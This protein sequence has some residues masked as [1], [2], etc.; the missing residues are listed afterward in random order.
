MNFS[1]IIPIYN[2]EK[3]LNILL[4]EL[5]EL[6]INLEIILINDGSTDSTE[7]ILR[8]QKNIKVI[9]NKKNKGKGYSIINAAKQINTDNI[10]LM[11]GDLEINLDSVSK[12]INVYEK[13]DNQ[14][15]VGCRW[16]NKSNPGKHINTYGN[17]LINYLFN[18]LYGTDLNDV[19]CC[20]KI[21]NKNLFN[22]LNL[23]SNGFNIEM[24]I[25]SKLARKN[26]KFSEK[27]VIYNR[28]KSSEGKKIK[29]SDSLGIIKEMVMNRLKQV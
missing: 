20:V 13:L 15:V 21:I 27:N 1:L 12:L 5:E 7:S 18:S 14:V 16:N 28:R 3:T 6:N 25:M 19:L 11:D 26:I 29:L 4:N 2:E 17:Y 10:I 23:K 8:N 24:E 9:H 22:S